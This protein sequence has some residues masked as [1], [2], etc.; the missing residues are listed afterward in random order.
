KRRDERGGERPFGEKIAQHVR[1]SKRHQKRVQISAGAEKSGKHLLANQ[2]EHAAA[3]NRD[4]DDTGRTR[5]DSLR[6]GRS[7][8]AEK[9]NVCRFAKGKTSGRVS[10]MLMSQRAD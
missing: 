9:N 6:W 2:A 1:H 5:A 4:A 10:P 7:H 3:Q 8:R